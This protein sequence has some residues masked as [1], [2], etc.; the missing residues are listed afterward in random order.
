MFFLWLFDTAGSIFGPLIVL[1]G[2]VALLLCV[3]ATRRTERPSV[4]KQAL[5]G[6]LTPLALG[7]CAALV[8]L[9]L[10]APGGMKDEYWGNLGKVILAGLVVTAVP[11]VW[12]LCLMSGR[13]AAA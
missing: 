13:K 8:G 4:R 1:A 3:R 10:F 12:T 2:C 7:L 9:A 6:A 5:Y 11:L